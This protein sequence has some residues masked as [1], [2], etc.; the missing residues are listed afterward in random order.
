MIFAIGTG[1]FAAD[2]FLGIVM[3]IGL[4]GWALKRI[5][6]ADQVHK[7]TGEAAARGIGK[8]FR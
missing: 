5:G 8:L 7:A 2:A 4:G 1:S 3:L 6:V